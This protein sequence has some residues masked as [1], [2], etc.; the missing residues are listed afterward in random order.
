MD[1]TCAQNDMRIARQQAQDLDR[2]HKFINTLLSKDD[3]KDLEKPD[4][5]EPPKP[6]H[7]V[8]GNGVPF[9][10]PK[11]RFS[12]P[13]APPPQQP[14]P[15]K[16][17]VPSLKRGT[18]ERPKSHPSNTSPI[19]QDNLAQILHLTEALND[20]KRKID[21]Q[22]NLMRE[23]EDRLKKE[24]EARELAE[25]LA[26]RLEDAAATNS[27]QMNGLAKNDESDTLLEEAFEP[28]RDASLSPELEAPSGED[29]RTLSHA[30]TVEAAATV[31][32]AKI[33]SLIS[34]MGSVKQELEAWKQRCERAEAERDVSRKSLAE[35]VA[36]IRRDKEIE[37]AR[38][39]GQL[40]GRGRSKGRKSPTLDLEEDDVL[41][42]AAD[43][44]R[45]LGSANS[46]FDG[47]GEDPT[48]IPPLSRENTITPVTTMPLSKA[49][50]EPAVMAS[51]PYASMMGVVLIG[52]GLMAY[53]NGWQPQPKLDR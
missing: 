52:M 4:V 15:E 51:L 11:A 8:N 45:D 35:L 22:S 43:G 31:Q 13:P 42:T 7:L 50:Q 17:D 3:V 20:A 49:P 14:L 23:L 10:D 1:L 53:I 28:P 21:T 26:K 27:H 2:T 5:P 46:Q 41:T 6:Q 33:E 34:E 32:Q 48:E 12:D 36:Q 18:T 39:A 25:D 24:R 9:R 16:P 30:D 19:R 38:A 29:E 44:S 40:R 47:S 37:L